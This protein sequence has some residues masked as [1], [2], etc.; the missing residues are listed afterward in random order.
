V[1]RSQFL[2]FA[3][4]FLTLALAAGCKS[5]GTVV[6]NAQFRV[7]N[8]SAEQPDLDVLLTT[9]TISSDLVYPTATSYTQES[10]GGYTLHIQP[11]GTTTTLINLPLVFQPGD[12]RTVIAAQSAFASPA[13]TPI[14]LTDDNSAPNSGQMKLRVVNASPDIGNLDV[15]IVPPGSSLAGK[16]PTISSL[17]FQAA[18][19]YQSLAAGT[20]VVAFTPAGQKNILINTEVLTFSAT[21]IRTLV[22][23]DTTGGYS[24]SLLSD[25]N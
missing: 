18:S 25:V 4:L 12:V 23:L 24:S 16:T 6:A 19:P 9:T 22:A 3:V 17:A 21:Q 5:A 7:M 11:T 10:P 15:Y 8:A 14:L 1:K 20:Y 13:L 2:G